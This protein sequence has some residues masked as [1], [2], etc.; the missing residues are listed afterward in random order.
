MSKRLDENGVSYLWGKIKK[1]FL[2]AA[3]K[4]KAGGVAEL[5]STGK[6][7]ANQ[8]PSALPASGGDA[9]TV[10]G[11]TVKTD[12][13]ENAVFTDTK[14]VNMKGATSSNAGAAGYAPAPSAGAQDKYLRGDGTWQTP[15]N[16]TYSA[17]TT[18]KDGLMISADK[19]KL[20]GFLEAENYALKTDIS[21]VYKYKGSV[22]TAS[23]LP[24][25]GQIVG[26][27]YNIEAESVYGPAG[28]NV[29]WDGTA[30]DTLGGI[31]VMESITNAELDAIC[32]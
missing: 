16:T 17:V 31:F 15:P 26:Y 23:E 27:V 1:T 12:V 32:V 20:D 30:W 21:T 9:D 28:Q 2:A 10:G 8:L 5:D 19:K 18:S 3:T 6:V 11:H 24:T 4:G 25:E 22:K 7:P 14:P 29:A 13:P